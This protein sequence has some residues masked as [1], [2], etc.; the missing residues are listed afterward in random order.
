[1]NDHIT[2]VHWLSYY[3][4]Y[5]V[6]YNMYDIMWCPNKSYY[7]NLCNTAVFVIH[8]L[9]HYIHCIR[10]FS[11]A[12]GQFWRAWIHYFVLVHLDQAVFVKVN[13]SNGLGGWTTRDWCWCWWRRRFRAHFSLGKLILTAK[14][15]AGIGYQFRCFVVDGNGVCHTALKIIGK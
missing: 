13:R 2:A 11:F 4:T 6:I 14:F 9:L 3:V 1:M 5:F 12:G 10:G 7:Y 15:G 8:T